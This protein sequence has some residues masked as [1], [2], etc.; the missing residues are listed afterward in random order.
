LYD[1]THQVDKK[2]KKVTSKDCEKEDVDDVNSRDGQIH[3][4]KQEDD[5]K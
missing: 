1:K 2:A 5:S 3:Q 4:W